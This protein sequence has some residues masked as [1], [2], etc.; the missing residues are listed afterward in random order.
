MQ[1]NTPAVLFTQRIV[2]RWNNLHAEVV[3]PN[4]FKKREDLFM[5]DYMY[6]V[7]EPPTSIISWNWQSEH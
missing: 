1:Y 5:R 6:C 4:A 7:E 3:K 2:D